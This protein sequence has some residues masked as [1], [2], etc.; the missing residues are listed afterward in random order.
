MSPNLEKTFLTN[1]LNMKK[2][3]ISP[4]LL[5]LL[6][7]CQPEDTSTPS[8]EIDEN[9]HVLSGELRSNSILLQCRFASIDTLI[10]RDIPGQAGGGLFQVSTDSLFGETLETEWLPATAEGDFIIKKQVDGLQPDTPYFY[11]VKALLEGQADT[12]LSLTGTFETFPEEGVFDEIS[13]AMSTGFNYE[14][15]YG[16]EYNEEQAK[17][18]PAKIPAQGKDRE[19]GFE[20]FEAVQGKGVDFFIANGD[21][22]YYDK[23]EKEGWGAKTV[24]EMRAKW[25]RF[26]AMPRNRSLNRAMPVFFLKDDHDHRFN[27][28]DTTNRK[29]ELPTNQDGIAIFKEQVPVVD[30]EDANPKTYRTVRVNADLQLWFVEGRDYR[31]PNSMEDTPEKTI[32]GD[33]QKAWLKRT[34]LESDAPFKILVSPTPMIGPDDAYKRDNHTNPEGFQ[35]EGREFFSWLNENGFTGDDL[36]FICG[37]RHWKYHSVRPDGFQE[38]SCG[39][40]VDQNSRGGRLPGDPKS[41]DPDALLKVPFIEIDTWGGG[42]LQVQSKREQNQSL[43]EFSF[44]D[45]SGKQLYSFQT[46]K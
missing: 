22:V 38:F 24:E 41:S 40:F 27:D 7:A 19:L 18:N 25:H 33:E 1:H 15:F 43:M 11:R 30:P 32:W 20:A 6:F 10:N 35:S 14:F 17:K 28:C 31:S 12:V 37:D 5:A 39:A 26:F 29:R 34:L 13:F 4:L 45:I 21:V 44:H 42:Y 46:E 2:N 9:L 23:G 16:I 8:L 36:F 3:I